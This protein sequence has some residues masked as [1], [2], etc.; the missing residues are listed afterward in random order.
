[1][2]E[3][4]FDPDTTS[5]H[6]QG[7]RITKQQSKTLKI[8][9]GLFSTAVIG[10]AL[11]LSASSTDDG[12]N[13]RSSITF[14]AP[15]AAGGGWDTFAREMQQA[16]RA[17]GIVNNTQV[18]NVPGAGGTIALEN[19]GRL[20]GETDTLMVGGTGQLAATIQYDSTTTYQDITPLALTVEE[21]DVIL[22]PND[23]PYQTLNELIT[24]WQKDPTALAWS[25]GGSFDRLVATEL[26]MAADIRPSEMTYVS[27]DGGAEVTQALLNG[28][29]QAA[30]S[31]YADSIDQIESG[32]LRALALIA[33]EPIP[34]FDVPTA[35]E[36]GYDVTLANWRLVL[37]PGGISEQDKAELL[38]IV[39]ES[40]Q[41]PEWQKAVTTYHWQENFMTGQ[42]LES[43]LDSEEQ[44]ISGI[45][46]ELGL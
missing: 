32:R 31:G 19:L 46:Q 17:N 4:P 28:T 13:L 27:S 45:Y 20:K 34:G 21:Y 2:A 39:Q 11:F 33:E 35:K 12:S 42:E 26:A 6:T 18:V 14:I 43:F 29:V 8:L 25:G 22:V 1:M 30:A 5:P 9:G 24:A 23:S 44:R 16:Q 37:A 7:I 38:N 41:T 36:A 15:A 10:S 40:T 3:Q